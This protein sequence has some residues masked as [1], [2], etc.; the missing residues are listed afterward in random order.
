MRLPYK[1]HEVIQSALALL[2]PPPHPGGSSSVVG[3]NNII[4]NHA[5]AHGNYI[6]GSSEHVAHLVS[7]IGL[8]R[9]KRSELTTLLM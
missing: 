7:K 2:V 6:S 4:I 3:V 5:S 8:F 9:E 1:Y